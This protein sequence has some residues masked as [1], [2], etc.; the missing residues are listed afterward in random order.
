M[1]RGP[2]L[3]PRGPGRRV[4]TPRL[5]SPA[6][7]TSWSWTSTASAVGGRP[8]FHWRSFEEDSRSSG[9]SPR[10]ARSCCAAGPAPAAILPHASPPSQ[11]SP[12]DTS[13]GARDDELAGARFHRPRELRARSGGRSWSPEPSR[14]L[15]RVSGRPRFHVA[16]VS[17]PARGDGDDDGLGVSRYRRARPLRPYSVLRDAVLLLRVHRDTALGALRRRPLHGRAPARARALRGSHRPP[18]EDPR[19]VRHRRGGP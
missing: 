1:S 4:P 16:P 8:P 9:G 5:N 14:F 19:G 11:E 15:D 17:G 18:D 7:R 2:W 6:R 13:P 3:P 10:K 12:A